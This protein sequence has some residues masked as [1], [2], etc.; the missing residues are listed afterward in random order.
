MV[1]RGF[2]TKDEFR[3]MVIGQDYWMNTKE[4]CKRGIATHVILEGKEI[5]AKEYLKKIKKKKKKTQKK[6]ETTIEESKN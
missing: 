1:K 4:L 2:L 5:T 3:K 6:E